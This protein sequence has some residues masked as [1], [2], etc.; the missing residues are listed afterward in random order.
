ME[1][2]RADRKTVKL[3]AERISCTGNCSVFIENL[4]ETGIKMITAPHKENDFAPGKDID[5]ELELMS[6]GTINLNC[7]VKW[8]YDDPSKDLSSS[9]GLEI[10]EPPAVYRKFVKA[11]A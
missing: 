6:G 3:R 9:V 2:R 7:N 11:I 8:S 4:S 5:L 10:I 1:R